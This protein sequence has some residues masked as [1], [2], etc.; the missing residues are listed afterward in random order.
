MTNTTFYSISEAARQAQENIQHVIVGKSDVIELVLVAIL[1]EGHVLIEDVPGTGKTLLA[2]S[3]A[4]SLGC[5]FRRIQC[6]PDILPSDITGTHIYNQK[7]ND[8]EFRPGPIFAQIVLTD[9]INRAT[10]RTQSAL[11]EAMEEI[12][13]GITKIVVALD[14]QTVLILGGDG[15]LTPVPMGP[16]P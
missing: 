13:P 9:E 6:T 16:N 3:I 2:R 5:T 14:A 10:P 15:Q 12:M 4:Q 11:L 8:F 1:C 7:T